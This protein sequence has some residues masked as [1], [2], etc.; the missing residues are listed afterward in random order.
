MT[1]AGQTMGTV[2][3]MSPEQ[4][5]G[6]AVDSRSALWSLGVLAYEVLA[7][8]S[9]F[10]ADSSAATAMRILNDEPASLAAVPGIPDWLAR[11]VSQLLQKSSAAHPQTGTEVYCRHGVATETEANTHMHPD[12]SRAP[13]A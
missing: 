13:H 4:L 7:G 9:P 1:Q 3:Y 12:T 5:R 2:L 6:E 10:Q 11:L 8:V